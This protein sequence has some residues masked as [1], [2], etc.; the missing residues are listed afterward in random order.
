MPRSKP[1]PQRSIFFSIPPADDLYRRAQHL[2]SGQD[3]A[4]TAFFRRTSEDRLRGEF[5]PIVER[6]TE[7]VGVT[8]KYKA[9]I[10]RYG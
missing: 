3:D 5:R 4:A 8:Q 1:C 10:G 7:Q 2:F 9:M 6:F